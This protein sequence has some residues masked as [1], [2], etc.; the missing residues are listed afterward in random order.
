M[1][2]RG[3]APRELN[4]LFEYGYAFLYSKIYCTVGWT[5]VM[6]LLEELSQ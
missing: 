3:V 6:S 1:D 2:K 5:D 4:N